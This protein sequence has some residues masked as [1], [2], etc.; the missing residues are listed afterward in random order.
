MDIISL[1][2]VLLE[3]QFEDETMPEDP[4]V[5]KGTKACNNCRWFLQDTSQCV[6]LDPPDVSPQGVCYLWGRG[7]PSSSELM[8]PRMKVSHKDANYMEH[9]NMHPLN[10]DAQER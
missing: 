8:R 9:Y 3:Y 1:K 10:L 6:V 7:E 2:K 4:E 5:E